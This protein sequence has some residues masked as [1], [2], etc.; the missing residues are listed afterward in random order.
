MGPSMPPLFT[1][2]GVWGLL[3]PGFF[4]KEANMQ[5]AYAIEGHEGYMYN[6]S[7]NMLGA[8]MIAVAAVTGWVCAN[9]VPF[10][11]ILKCLGVFRVDPKIEEMGM[12][13]GEHGGEA[14]YISSAPKTIMTTGKL[15][16]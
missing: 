4:A 5:A 8:Q 3:A 7:M 15:I 13:K 2:A 14:Y 1:F 10:F 12:D 16:R 9:M 11:V 6:A